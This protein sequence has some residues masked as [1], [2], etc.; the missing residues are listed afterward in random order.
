MQ[1]AHLVLRLADTQAVFADYVA[2]KYSTYKPSKPINSPPTTTGSRQTKNSWGMSGRSKVSA[3]E[4]FFSVL[5][6][7][8]YSRVELCLKGHQCFHCME[9]ITEGG[10]GVPIEIKKVIPAKVVGPQGTSTGIPNPSYTCVV[11]FLEPTCSFQCALAYIRRQRDPLYVKS[12]AILNYVWGLMNP[13]E[14]LH[15]APHP[16]FLDRHGGPLPKDQWLPGSSYWAAETVQ[17]LPMD[18]QAVL[19]S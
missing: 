15:P 19:L 13:N 16:L 4:D 6:E 3:R 10:V 8:N 7:G 9:E 14:P 12:E 17:Y 1:V 18:I 2:G 5:S 11:H